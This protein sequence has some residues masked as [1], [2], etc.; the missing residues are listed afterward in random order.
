MKH[1]VKSIVVLF[2]VLLLSS[3]KMYGKTVNV[4]VV[5][6]DSTKE[7]ITQYSLFSEYYK[8]KDYKSAYPFGWKVLEMNPEKFAKWI[9]YKMED[10]LWYLHDSTSASPEELKSYADTTVYLYDLAMK[11]YPQDKSY[12]QVRKAFVKETWY[13]LPAS[14][15]ITE[16]EKAISWDPKISDYY[17]NRLGQLYKAAASDSN[18]YK[19]KAIDL[20]TMLQEKDPDN[21][22]WNSELESLVENRD[23]LVDLAKKAWELDKDNLSKAWKYA[24]LAMRESRYKEAAKVLEFLVSKEPTT[25]NYWN[26]LATAYQRL[27]NTAKAEE[28]YRKL[29][30]LEPEKKEHYLNLGIILADKGNY[31]AARA[32]YLKASKLGNGWGLPIY[33]EGL[34][35]EKS[36]RNCEFNFEAKLVY[37]LAVNTYYRAK[38]MDPTV[39]QAQ[40]RINALSSSTPTKEDYFFRGYKSGQVIPITGKCYS[41]I[42]RSITVP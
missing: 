15:V 25:V 9:Y 14:E 16:Y 24:S 33:Y 11:Y 27:E 41:W 10:I 30:S 36:A 38:S 4:S 37:Q 7:L 31:S 19:S 18:N 5:K 29:I 1:I 17:F 28:A 8:N 6:T 42:E 12:F 34:L 26:Q 32:Q 22:A 35:Y 23:Q 40:A 2:V 13:N 39:T 20:Y 3:F 21:P